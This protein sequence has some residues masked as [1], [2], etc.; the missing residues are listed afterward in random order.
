M[1][2]RVTIDGESIITEDLT[3]DELV[4]IEKEAGEPWSFAIAAPLKTA[5]SGRAIATKLLARRYGPE[6]G[7][8]RA[9]AMTFKQILDAFEHVPDDRPEDYSKD[10]IPK[11]DPKAVAGV[12]GTTSS[13]GA[14]SDS[15]G[16]PT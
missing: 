13:S 4:E 8:K 14:S 9:G 7:A 10:G 11:P 5:A 16:L 1:P 2:F 15:G 3:L 6:E 12:T